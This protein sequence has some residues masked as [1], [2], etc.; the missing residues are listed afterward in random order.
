MPTSLPY[1]AVAREII[2][3]L[4]GDRTQAALGRKLGYKSSVIYRWE[5]GLRVPRA[6]TVLALASRLGVEV[7]SSIREFCKPYALSLRR[8][9]IDDAWVS[10]WLAKLAADIT[11]AEIARRSGVARTRVQ[12]MLSGTANVSWPDLLRLVDAI[13]SRALH[14]VSVFVD[15]ELLPSARRAWRELEA[16]RRLAIQHPLS[17]GVLALLRLEEY[18][19]LRSLGE[20]WIADRMRL[21]IEQ[22]RAML[23]AMVEGGV[24]RRS[25]RQYTPREEW[26]VEMTNVRGPRPRNGPV[27]MKRLAE[28]DLPRMSGGYVVFAC[29]AAVFE[30]V[31]AV[32]S[33]AYLETRHI[34]QD[35]GEAELA[36][37]F[38]NAL[39]D[40]S[41][42]EAHK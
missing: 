17:E 35:P 2:C 32:W 11:H 33:A 22:T 13:T 29:S 27:W 3:S 15:P 8:T 41:T 23:A 24:I 6:S 19:A 37:V 26:I 5:A 9:P 38:V 28:L 18:R 36:G 14:F 31:K 40:L 21:P 12:R 34:L 20:Q 10:D 39:S 16:Y 25:K 1:E 30:R 4:R 42:L 7:V